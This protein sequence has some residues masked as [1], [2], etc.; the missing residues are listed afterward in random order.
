MDTERGMS[1]SPAPIERIDRKS[2]DRTGSAERRAPSTLLF[3][4]A[5]MMPVSAQVGCVF[6]D[7]DEM[8]DAHLDEAVAARAGIPLPSRVGLH[9]R[10]DLV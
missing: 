7:D 4:P 6:G 1:P 9:G 2:S 5:S 10:D 8:K 3:E